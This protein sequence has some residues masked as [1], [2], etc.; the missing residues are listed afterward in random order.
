MEV[1]GM[2]REWMR[3]EIRNYES[4]DGTNSSQSSLA[5]QIKRPYGRGGVS[6]CTSCRQNH[7]RVIAP[8]IYL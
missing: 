6:K 1:D 2:S 7:K 4:E 5:R 3:E 8:E